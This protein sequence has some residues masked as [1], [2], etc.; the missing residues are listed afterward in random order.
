MPE[1]RSRT[2]TRSAIR[3]IVGGI[4]AWFPEAARDL[5]WRR[6]RDPWRCLV[7]ELMLQQTQVSRVSEMFEGFMA[8]FPT[9][10]AMVEAGEDAV[11]GAWKGLGYYRRARLLHAA[12]MRI[13]EEHGGAVPR[14]LELLKAL[15]GVGD[16]TAGAVASIA[17]GEVAPIVDG[18]VARVIARLD[19]LDLASDDPALRKHA[20][21]RAQ[22][23]AEAAGN[24]GILNEGL[25]ELGASIC[26]PAPARPACTSCPVRRHCQASRSGTAADLP[27]P[28]TRKARKVVVHHS[29][30]IWRDGHWLLQRRPEKGTWASMWELP[31]IES[32]STLSDAK[33]REKLSFQVTNLQLVDEFTHLLTHREVRFRIYRARS[34]VRRGEWRAPNEMEDMA[35]STAMR[36]A[37]RRLSASNED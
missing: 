27:R 9:P 36:R 23:F 33:L 20:W 34:R 26:L 5:P 14:D 22:D 10:N 3:S 29:V 25:M 8:R 6:N 12:A 11:L 13:V 32:P 2:R 7:S 15:P 4:E 31:S 28:K 17:F 1:N 21:S 18:N 24:P 30:A 35:M 16:Y 19:E 37:I